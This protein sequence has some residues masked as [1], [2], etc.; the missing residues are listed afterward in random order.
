M[1]AFSFAFDNLIKAAPAEVRFASHGLSPS[2]VRL[3]ARPVAMVLRSEFDA[4]LLDRSGAEVLDGSPVNS[5]AETE[6]AVRVAV[7]GRKTNAKEWMPH[8]A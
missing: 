7:G 2:D 5:L 1:D 8:A 3:S 4:F 6:D